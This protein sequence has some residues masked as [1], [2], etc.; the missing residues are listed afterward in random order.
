VPYTSRRSNKRT[1][2]LNRPLGKKKIRWV[3][4]NNKEKIEDDKLL[5]DEDRG[6]QITEREITE[7]IRSKIGTKRSLLLRAELYYY[8][9]LRYR[10]KT[11]KKGDICHRRHK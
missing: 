10:E 3:I 6:T 5:E 4:E 8:C 11:L 9:Y 7:A 2:Q 1:S